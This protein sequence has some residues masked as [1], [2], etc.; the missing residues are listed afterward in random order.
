VIAARY[1]GFRLLVFFPF[2]LAACSASRDYEA[3]G[4]QSIAAAPSAPARFSWDGDFSCTAHVEGKLPAITWRRI[5]FRQEGDRVTGLYKF[6]DHFNHRNS[7]MFSGTLNG[8]NARIDAIAVRANGSPNFTAEMS[9]SRTLM[10]GW[11][12]SGMSRQPV[13]SCTLALSPA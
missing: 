4:R 9:G 7:V 12:M 3:A 6:T 11:M 5:P 2:L 13:R 10:T 8:R 1:A